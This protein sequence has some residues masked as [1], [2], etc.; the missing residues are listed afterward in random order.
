MLLPF[1]KDSKQGDAFKEK[2]CQRFETLHETY[3][4][5]AADFDQA[6]AAQ[7]ATPTSAAVEGAAPFA[8][9][10]K[11]VSMQAQL[12]TVA[13]Q[14][15][16]D[17]QGPQEGVSA[18]RDDMSL[19]SDFHTAIGGGSDLGAEEDARGGT[20]EVQSAPS[21]PN[22]APGRMEGMAMVKKE[23][24]M[25]PEQARGPVA[26]AEGG[27]VPLTAAEDTVGVGSQGGGGAGGQPAASVHLPAASTQPPAAST[28]LPAPFH[29]IRQ[30]EGGV[31]QEWRCLALCLKE[32]G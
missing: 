31:V 4:A 24:G 23:P 17:G 27:A 1:V 29:G 25:V 5:T 22:G 28:Q 6:A 3:A 11:D 21:Q 30:R 13:P 18:V 19:C 20:G 8:V 15:P 32:M 2:L 9:E 7:R 16:T 14:L 12:P 26:E 10:T